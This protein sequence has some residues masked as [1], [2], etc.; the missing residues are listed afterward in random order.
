[1][2][3][4]RLAQTVAMPGQVLRPDM[5]EGMPAPPLFAEGH[6]HNTT[7]YAILKHVQID[8]TG[9][10]EAE[11]KG[12]TPAIQVRYA[13]VLLNYAEALAE[14]DGPGNESRIIAA[15]KPLRDRVGMPAMD[16]DREYN[17]E[18][19]YPFRNLNKYIQAVR[20]ER[21]V[22]QA[23]EG[24]RFYDIARWAA[25]DVLLVNWTPLGALFTGSNLPTLRDNFSELV[26][27]QDSGNNLFLTGVAGD[28][29]RYIIPIPPGTM[30]GGYKFKENRDY[31]LPFQQRLL[32]LTGNKWQ[33]NPGW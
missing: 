9:N 26:Y 28:A 21:R 3:D 4:P 10:L 12:A 13:D 1:M 30:S 8:Y 19:D 29:R 25:A 7:G 20:R 27:D 16:F 15:L 31:L 2:R 18:A 6:H 17:T 32:T 11:Y 22:E 23:L 24:R 14:L 5:Q 33:Q